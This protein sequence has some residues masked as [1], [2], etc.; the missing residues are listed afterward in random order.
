MLFNASRGAG[1][2]RSLTMKSRLGLHR[3]DMQMGP[4]LLPTPLHR[5]R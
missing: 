3:L 1:F 5:L 4:A 2:A